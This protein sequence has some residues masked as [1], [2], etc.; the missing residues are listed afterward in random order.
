MATLLAVGLDVVV[1]VAGAGAGVRA[2]W[3]AGESARYDGVA[4]SAKAGC[5][6]GP[7]A[8]IA[9]VVAGVVIGGIINIIMVG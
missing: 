7:M 2:L 8:L 1:A 9:G 6:W 5:G 3:V 4:A